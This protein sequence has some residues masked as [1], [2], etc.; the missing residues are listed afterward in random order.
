MSPP[1]NAAARAAL[2]DSRAQC[3]A[4]GEPRTEPVKACAALQDPL[5]GLP[6]LLGTW[7]GR[8]RTR[9]D[10]EMTQKDD[11]GDFIMVFVVSCKYFL[12]ALTDYMF[13]QVVFW[14]A[15]IF[16]KKCRCDVKC[17]CDGLK[18]TCYE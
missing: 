9:G 2:A 17:R 4:P 5:W 15:K 16:A 8:R 12:N 3:N 10:G 13:G 1:N 14:R 11:S 7:R 18:C 6:V